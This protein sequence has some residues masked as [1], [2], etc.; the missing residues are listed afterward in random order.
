MS[1]ARFFE[2][3]GS[4]PGMSFVDEADLL[5]RT[6]GTGEHIHM[7]LRVADERR[8]P[9]NALVARRITVRCKDCGAVCWYDPDSA[10]L[11]SR[12]EIVCIQCCAVRGAA[13]KE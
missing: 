12:A 1:H 11:A 4:N 8:P 13:K 6:G 3:F 9:S 7:V 5:E 2:L 10:L